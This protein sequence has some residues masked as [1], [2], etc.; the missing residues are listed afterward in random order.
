MRSMKRG[1]GVGFL[2]VAAAAG[3]CSGYEH[4]LG[5]GGGGGGGAGV[6]A[7]AAGMAF[8]AAAGSGGAAGDAGADCV[9]PYIGGNAGAVATPPPIVPPEGA[10]CPIEAFELCTKVGFYDAGAY[11]ERTLSRCVEGKWKTVETLSDCAVQGTEFKDCH[12]YYR[13]DGVCCGA[14]DNGS[15]MY[16]GPV[17][18]PEYG[19]P[20]A[21]CDGVRWWV[22]PFDCAKVGGQCEALGPAGCSEGSWGDAASYSCGAAIGVGCCLPFKPK[23]AAIQCEDAG[24]QCVDLTPDGCT[25]GQWL[26]AAEYD[27]GGVAGVGCCKPN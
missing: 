6:A 8:D 20:R 10:P 5:G 26:P 19:K 11:W 16:P 9:P 21:F 7:G 27:C 25:D 12:P 3:S 17:Y 13:A 2:A 1:F 4:R 23:P 22:E 15:F 18:C 14:K 24:G